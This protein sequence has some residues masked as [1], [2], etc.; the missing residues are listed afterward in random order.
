VRKAKH[1]SE[2][3]PAFDYRAF[4]RDQVPALE[5]K[6]WVRCTKA[7]AHDYWLMG[8]DETLEAAGLVAMKRLRKPARGV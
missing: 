8:L 4:D 3:D 7:E 6:R 2:P 5:A 1:R